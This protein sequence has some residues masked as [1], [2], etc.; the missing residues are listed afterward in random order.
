MVGH[1]EREGDIKIGSTAGDPP[2]E[3]EIARRT[4]MK[5]EG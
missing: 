4:R 1:Y 5:R 3:L 2:S